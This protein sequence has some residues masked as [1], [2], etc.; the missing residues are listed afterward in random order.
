MLRTWRDEVRSRS[1]ISTPTQNHET[2]NQNQKQRETSGNAKHESK[3]GRVWVCFEPGHHRKGGADHLLLY[4][5]LVS[6]ATSSLLLAQKL[7]GGCFSFLTQNRGEKKKQE[8]TVLRWQA[9]AFS[10]SCSC[11]RVACLEP[12]G[13]P[14][15][16]HR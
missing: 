9:L 4:H 11:W 13:D 2:G 10:C 8:L 14:M 1:S 7:W 12:Q 16:P 3:T 5:P 15:E 6:G